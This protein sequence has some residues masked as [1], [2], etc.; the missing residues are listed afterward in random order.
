MTSNTRCSALAAPHAGIPHAPIL[1]LADWLMSED[2]G[3]LGSI[4]ESITPGMVFAGDGQMF[5][6]AIQH[7]GTRHQVEMV[8]PAMRRKAGAPPPLLISPKPYL[9]MHGRCRV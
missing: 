2:F 5:A 4:M 6:K 8:V 1:L 3:K 9:I 7:G